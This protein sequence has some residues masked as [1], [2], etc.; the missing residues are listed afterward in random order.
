MK[1]V[2]SGK[3]MTNMKNTNKFK[4]NMNKKLI[5]EGITNIIAVILIISFLFYVIFHV[6]NLFTVKEKNT[7]I[8]QMQVIEKEEVI[9][10]IGTY[11]YYIKLHNEN[12]DHSIIVSY[13]K[14]LAT[15]IG[16]IIDCQIT[17][18]RL[19]IGNIIKI[20]LV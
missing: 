11:K 10:S 8:V 3:N 4:E 9:T 15:N 7:Y 13:P 19:K 6:I 18:I 16:D 14:Y 12:E 1:I 2:N 20:D 17:K 5:I